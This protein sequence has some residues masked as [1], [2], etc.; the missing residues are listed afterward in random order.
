MPL[1]YSSGRRILRTT[2][3]NPRRKL[4]AA[5]WNPR[6]KLTGKSQRCRTG[7]SQAQRNQQCSEGSDSHPPVCGGLGSVDIQVLVSGDCQ[8]RVMVAERTKHNRKSRAS[9][10]EGWTPARYAVPIRLT[11]RQERYCRRAIGI[12][13]FIYNLRV[14]THR[15]CRM[16]RMPWTSWRDIYKA[17]NAAKRGLPVLLRGRQ[18]RSGGN[19]HGLRGR[20]AQL[21][22]PG[23]SRQ[24]R[25]ASERNAG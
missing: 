24:G 1:R 20:A 17:F 5:V 19:F 6:W 12:T 23:P 18:P 10:P 15:F 16:N 13:R 8:I 21:A 2:A 11:V 3:W 9:C 7:A 14:A 22:R 4:R 25:P